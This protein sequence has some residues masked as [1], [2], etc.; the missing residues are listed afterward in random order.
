MK[1]INVNKLLR[2][3]VTFKFWCAAPVERPAALCT[4]QGTWSS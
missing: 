1:A 2:C 3:G 4:L